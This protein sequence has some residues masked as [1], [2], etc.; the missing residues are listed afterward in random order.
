MSE[1]VYQVILTFGTNAW[2]TT[3]EAYLDDQKT[4][5][6]K[7]AKHRQMQMIPVVVATGEEIKLTPGAH[8]ELTKKVIAE[9]APRFT[10]GSEVI[11]VGDTGDK[12]GYFQEARL[13]QL[14]VTVDRHGKMPDVVLYFEDK[15]WLLLVESVISHGPVDA[16][17]HAELVTLF[18]H[19]APGLVYVTAFPDRGIMARYLRD[20]SWETEVWCA[21]APTHLVH[22]NGVRFL[23]PYEKTEGE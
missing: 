16:K 22:F 12:V 23:G 5:A 20:I 19:A 21:D 6:A 9:F 2:E 17:R 7:W 18:E 3:L 14:G 15:D 13:A 10:P 1:A 8:S 11:Y 4:L